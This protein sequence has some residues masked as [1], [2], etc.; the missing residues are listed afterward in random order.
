MPAY[1][2]AKTYTYI[3]K[4]VFL[5]WIYYQQLVNKSWNCWS[6][7]LPALF[8]GISSEENLLCATYKSG[9]ESKKAYACSNRI[10]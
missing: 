8:T 3:H 7:N 9:Y 5:V 6:F 10:L 4:N 2:Y 1:K